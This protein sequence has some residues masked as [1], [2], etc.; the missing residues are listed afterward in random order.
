[1]RKAQNL[2]LRRLAELA[3]VDYSMLS[4]V[5]R[6][7]VDPSARWLKDVTTALGHHL[8]GLDDEDAA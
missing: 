3:D 8:A 4:R 5:E 1:M 7:E 2:S 6:G